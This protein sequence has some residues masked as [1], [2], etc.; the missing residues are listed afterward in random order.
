VGC[1]Q[2][3][4]A[5]KLMIGKG[6][7]LEGRLLLFDAMEMDFQSVKLRWDPEC[8]VCG[9]HPEITELIDYDL[10]CG[11]PSG[12]SATGEVVG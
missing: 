1:I 10:F 2:A 5:I 8:P 12:A 6:R 11:L 9:K 3:T 7:T 4:E